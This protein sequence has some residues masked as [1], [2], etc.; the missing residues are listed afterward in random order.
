MRKTEE[1]QGAR[2]LRYCKGILLGGGLPFASAWSFC[3]W[4]R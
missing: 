2:L 1:E 3:S 4:R